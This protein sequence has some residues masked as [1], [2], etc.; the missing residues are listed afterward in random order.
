ML[1][2]S[3]L[4][5]A[6]VFAAAVPQPSTSP[7]PLPLP[8]IG[9][10]RATSAACSVMRDLVIPSFGAAHHADARFA[11]MGKRLG[12]YADIIDDDDLKRSAARE[13]TLAQL[14]RDAM[15]LVQSSNVIKSALGDKRFAATATDPQIIA[16]RTQLQQLYGVQAERARLAYEFVERQRVEIGTLGIA[17]SDAFGGQ[18]NTPEPV[19]T[20]ARGARI[21]PGMPI[22]RGLSDKDSLSSWTVEVDSATRGTEN[23]A[24]RTFLGIAQSCR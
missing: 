2:A 8:E 4:L 21:I 11:E 1:V 10:V 16:Q 22:L 3:L 18:R 7:S 24:A 9:R 12:H 23:Q 20:E 14:D 5:S 19:P 6:A 13:G 17:G 15:D